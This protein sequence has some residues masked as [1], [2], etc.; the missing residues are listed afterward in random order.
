MKISK[1]NFFQV[2]F[3][4]C[5]GFIAGSIVILS[6]FNVADELTLAYAFVV[7]VVASVV[8]KVMLE[9]LPDLRRFFRYR[10]EFFPN[11]ACATIHVSVRMTEDMHMSFDSPNA[12]LAVYGKG[13]IAYE[14]QPAFVK[15]L[16]KIDG[17]SSVFVKP[18]EI[19]LTRGVC[20]AWEEIIPQALKALKAELADG[21][22][23]IEFGTPIHPKAE[24]ACRAEVF[25]RDL[26]FER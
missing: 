23:L 18:Y 15:E 7:A 20:I 6:R 2:A 13:P 8:A 17:V 9:D 4:A 21:R 10:F 22:S 3:A 19:H 24:P 14:E 12:K 1:F 26:S 16:F 11:P 25:D 5:A